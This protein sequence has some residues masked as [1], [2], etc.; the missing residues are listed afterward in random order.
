MFACRNERQ[1]AIVV[2]VVSVEKQSRENGVTDE[3]HYDVFSTQYE[4]LQ[5]HDCSL[6]EVNKNNTPMTL[7]SNTNEHVL[8]VRQVRL[9]SLVANHPPAH[10]SFTMAAEVEDDP[11]TLGC[12]SSSSSESS[13]TIIYKCH[14]S[15]Y[16]F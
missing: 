7:I 2:F 14:Y 5:K 1:R 10:L 13:I 11:F 16:I 4:K 6:G 9:E 12:F 3:T 8:G 15:Y